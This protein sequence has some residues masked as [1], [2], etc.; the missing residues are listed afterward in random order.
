MATTYAELQ[1][2]IAD[3]LNRDDLASVVPTF[4]RLAESQMSRDIR[5]YQMETRQVANATEQYLTKP[6]DWVETIRL[7]VTGSGTSPLQLVSRDTLADMRYQADDVG[8]TP[9]YYAH[10]GNTFELYPTPSESTELELFYLAKIPALSD[11]NT[12][13]W[14]LDEA[15]DVY[16]YAS[17]IH[18]AGYLHEDARA[19]VWAQLYAS[20]I[21][22]LNSTSEKA[23]YS[24]SGLKMTIRGLS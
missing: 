13:N 9:C 21:Q 19:G 6:A 7:H 18:T 1:T 22:R 16:L 14:V 8:G 15:P 20:A 17:L 23:R 3:F 10:S 4:I 12:T 5:H 24:G 2:E 11:S